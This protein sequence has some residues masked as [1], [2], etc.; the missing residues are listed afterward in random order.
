MN[1]YCIMCR[2]DTE[3]IDS[4]IVRTKNNR[5][6]MQS[7]CCVC[8][9]K[10]SRFLKEQEAKALLSNLGIK[11]PLSKIPLLNVLF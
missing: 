8:G 9:I 10:K 11:T 2:K 6:V 3:N 5:P 1:T 4:K 7:K